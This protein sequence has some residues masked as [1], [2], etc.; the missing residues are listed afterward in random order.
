VVTL[1]GIVRSEAGQMTD[2]ILPIMSREEHVRL[3][4]QAAD[5][6]GEFMVYYNRVNCRESRQF[7]AVIRGRLGWLSVPAQSNILYAKLFTTPQ[8][9]PAAVL[10][11]SLVAPVGATVSALRVQFFYIAGIMIVLS[12]LIAYLTSRAIARPI[13]RIGQRA[14]TLAQG[15]YAPSFRG[16]GYREI[17]DLADTLNYAAGELSRVD[18]MRRDLMANVSHDLRTPLTLISGYAEAMTDLPGEASPENARIIAEETRRLTAL[19]N[20]M[21]DIS[22][23]ESGKRPLRLSVFSLTDSLAETVR[24]LQML[25][26]KD[27]YTIVFQAEQ[28]IWV[29]ADEEMVSQAFYNLLING[30]HYTGE[31]RT[32]IVA[33]KA[34]AQNVTISVTDSGPGIAPEHV[35]YIWD[36]YYK[37]DKDHRRPVAGTGLGLSIVRWVMEEHGARYGVHSEPEKGSEFWFSLPVWQ[38]ENRLKDNKEPS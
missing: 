36:R 29:H 1:T 17:D 6:G 28:N 31:D 16:G 5:N 25:V 27:S 22:R 24:R 3:I 7:G 23:L 13:H 38:G 4:R 34:D 15:D 2:S 33:Q 26:E 30:I 32:V 11:S 12:I 8:G 20:D 35:P 9:Q 14:R 19:V 10:I 21:L 18:Q 37:V